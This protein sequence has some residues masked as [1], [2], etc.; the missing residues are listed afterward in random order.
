MNK[1]FPIQEDN[2]FILRFRFHVTD[3]KKPPFS[4]FMSILLATAQGRASYRQL[5]RMIKMNED[6]K[7]RY[8]SLAQ[9]FYKSRVEGKPTAKKVSDAL[10][11][12]AHEYRP[13]Y[14]RILRI[15]L[16]FVA[17]EQGY[18][19]AADHIATTINPITSEPSRRTD[20][21][22]KQR[23]QRSVSNKDEQALLK[24]LFEN[25]E[26]VVA[27]A[28]TLVSYLGCRPAE[29]LKLTF[30]E[31]QTICI[32]SAKKTEDNKRGLDRE[33]RIDNAELFEIL[34]LSHKMLQDAPYTN[35]VRYVQRRLDTLTQRLWPKRK[36]RPSLYSWR[37]QMGS[38]LK[39][40][41]IDI[42]EIAAIMGHLST[43]SVNVYG[44][45]RSS[46]SGR[47][48]LKPLRSLVNFVKHINKA[49]SPHR[50]QSPSVTLQSLAKRME[51]QYGPSG[52]T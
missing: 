46:R 45:S 50:K 51:R 40:S 32:P 47:S 38:D 7:S 16:S 30:S 23:R 4:L 18:Y 28:I 14:W 19:K 2:P 1:Q 42:N 3:R 34:Q 35:P 6:T 10:K 36:V 21:K 22:P 43:E 52:A 41:N 11:D 24:Y 48:Y 27:A 15:A 37:H 29:L 8:R 12:C 13:D 31:Q 17:K 20:I 26:S 49:R 33:I 44:N 39:A 25:K 5:S 9:Y